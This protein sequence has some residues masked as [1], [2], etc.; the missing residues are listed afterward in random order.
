MFAIFTENRKFLPPIELQKA[1]KSIGKAAR[2]AQRA[3]NDRP[4]HVDAT[5]VRRWPQSRWL[6]KIFD[7]K[8]RELQP[9]NCAISAPKVRATRKKRA[10]SQRTWIWCCMAN[11]C[12]FCAC[13]AGSGRVSRAKI[14]PNFIDNFAVWVWFNITN[15]NAPEVFLGGKKRTSH[16][17]L[18]CEFAPF[19][20]FFDRFTLW[21]RALFNVGPMFGRRFPLWFRAYNRPRTLKRARINLEKARINIEKGADE[22]WRHLWKLRALKSSYRLEILNQTHHG[23]VLYVLHSK[24]GLHG[25]S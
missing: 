13:L 17:K 24:E 19:S 10:Q 15:Q 6:S 2:L 9:Q 3:A 23:G 5:C 8:S 25:I 16:A 20:M 7:T 21:I 11:V 12:N 22:G 14:A 1:G 4:H 18:P